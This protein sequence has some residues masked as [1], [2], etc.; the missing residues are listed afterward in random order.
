MLKTAGC[1]GAKHIA[2][3]AEGL[4]FDFWDGQSGLGLPTTRQS[5]PL[6]RFFE[7]ALPRLYAAEM[8]SVTRHTLYV[9]S[10]V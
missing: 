9:I 4:G 8:D 2:I 5:P 3:G 7:D 1:S 10:R 6:Q